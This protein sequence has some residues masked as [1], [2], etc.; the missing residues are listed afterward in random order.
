[1]TAKSLVCILCLI[2]PVI[3]HA[4]NQQ[5]ELIDSLELR[6]SSAETDWEKL[7]LA[8]GLFRQYIFINQVEKADSQ[9][10][11]IQS[12]ETT[13]PSAKA[14]RLIL[15]NIRAYFIE[16]NDDK[17]IA[18]CLEAIEL[19]KRQKNNNTLAYARYQLAENY[20]FEKGDTQKALDM[21]L[22]S[23]D[24]ID[25]SVSLKTT[26]NS[27]KVL[28]FIYGQMGEFE[29]GHFHFQEALKYLKELV[30]HPPLHPKTGKPSAQNVGPEMHVANTYNYI[31]DLYQKQGLTE[32]AIEEKLRGLA[33]MEKVNNEDQIAWM[34]S[35][36]GR[37]YASVGRLTDALERLQKSRI[38][39]EKLGSEKDIK[40]CNT[41]LINVLLSLEEYSDAEDYL[42]ENIIYY[43]EKND[44]T[45]LARTYLQGVRLYIK[46][47]QSEK[48][49]Y[50]LNKAQPIA[51][52]MEMIE[53]KAVIHRMRGNL[54]LKRNDHLEAISH[55]KEAILLFRSEESM[56]DIA[57]VK[58]EIAES[59]NLL[60]EYDS[61]LVYA[62]RSLADA[63]NQKD[64]DLAHDAYQLKSEIIAA[65]GNY[66]EAF[67][68]HKQFL[69]LH[70]S[71]Y[72][73]NA[74]AKLKEE[75]VRQNVV[76]Y[77]NEKE[78]AEQNA[79]L[80]KQQNRLYLIAGVVVLL[81][82]ILLVYLYF[83]L[84][85]VKLKVENQNDQLTQL[86]QTKDKFFGIIAHDLRSPLIGL[87]GVGDQ[88]NFFLKKGKTEK[89]ESMAQNI[90]DTSKKLTELLDNL[91]NWALLQNGM[92][93][94]Q[95]TKID[96][97]QSVNEVFDL[98]SPLAQMK[99]V[100]L[101]N[102]TQQNLSIYADKKAVNT[103]L[104]NL[105]AN[106]LKYTDKGGKVTVS[107]DDLEDRASI[108]IKDT[109]TGIS[110]EQIPRIFDLE[111]DSKEG[112]RGEKGSGLGL[113]LCKELVE[114]NKG[115]ISV[116]SKVG[117][118]STFKFDLP[119]NAD[120]A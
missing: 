52:R 76:S 78:L 58:L 49:S 77:R 3:L 29:K 36:I 67:I 38:M 70:D 12:L 57:R 103:I 118:G 110:T 97:N 61:A 56:P 46:S 109:G 95:P 21:I 9:L 119:K 55:F 7:D 81:I 80:L 66:K 13:I 5:Q 75:Q 92:I 117:M 48:A 54:A 71:L 100:T 18:K 19:S 104:R 26:G 59:Y 44:S 120:A 25:E 114:L 69:I 8:I 113:V 53:N 91:L 28:G 20:V 39:F 2:I 112:T 108:H 47:D 60:Q 86:N 72:A 85:K 83:N 74:Q 30:Q 23:L 84:R 107:I 96:V 4:Q 90:G 65:N 16:G 101:A 62:N 93:P 87:Q 22:L 10:N 6:V 14:Y 98:L 32:K 89:L 31:G 34:N 64:L 63:E 45:F 50:L 99:E 43:Q 106:A 11:I 111:K 102:S 33:M 15:E 116:D 115:S 40:Q 68:L 73:A 37:L 17:A 88:V 94:Y 51:E 24:E 1:M 82:L 42:E 79:S 35:Q 27:H 41:Y 105:I